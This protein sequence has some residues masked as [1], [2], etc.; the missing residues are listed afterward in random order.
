MDQRVIDEY[1]MPYVFS[2][3]QQIQSLNKIKTLDFDYG[4]IAHSNQVYSK[5]EIDSLV[6]S[7]LGVLMRYEADILRLLKSP[8]SREDLLVALL[9]QNQIVCNYS[10]YH[11][12]YSTVGAFLAKLANEDR[13]DYEFVQSRLCYFIKG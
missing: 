3:E 11:Y 9:E 12:N 5:D 6:D 2:V 13:I 7:N 4:V 10:S 8:R 1:D